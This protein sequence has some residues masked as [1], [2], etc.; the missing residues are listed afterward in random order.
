M[1]F[2]QL[3]V[4]RVKY[5]QSIPISSL[6]MSLISVLSN[7]TYQCSGF[8]LGEGEAEV[9]VDDLALLVHSVHLDVVGLEAA[10]HSNR[11]LLAGS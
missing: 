5:N 10:V 2:L 1:V 8:G 9:V 3:L 6:K 7:T 11:K 4:N